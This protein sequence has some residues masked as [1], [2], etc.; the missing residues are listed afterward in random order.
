VVGFKGRVGDAIDVAGRGGHV[1]AE[2]CQGVDTVRLNGLSKIEE[3]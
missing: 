1:K 3:C 2:F